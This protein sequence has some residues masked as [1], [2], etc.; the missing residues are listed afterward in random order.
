VVEGQWLMQAASDIFLGWCS[1]VGIDG[2]SRDFYVRQLWDGKGS[3]DV[4]AMDAAALE[5]YARLCGWTLARAH[6]RSGDAIAIGAYLGG[7]EAFDRALAEFSRL[8]ADQNERDFRALKEAIDS[9]RVVAE[10]A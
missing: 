2:K 4:E 5:I 10:D 6:G 9:G 1:V 7:G 8:Y 3:G